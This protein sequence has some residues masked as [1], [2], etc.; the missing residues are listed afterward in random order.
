MTEQLPYDLNRID[1][2][3]L[4]DDFESM[5]V[6]L[7]RFQGFM[8]SNALG[9][10]VPTPKA[11]SENAPQQVSA[12]IHQILDEGE[13]ALRLY[14]LNDTLLERR[15]KNFSRFNRVTY[16]T[17]MSGLPLKHVGVT[18]ISDVRVGPRRTLSLL[19]LETY[20]NPPPEGEFVIS[21]ADVAHYMQTGQ[22]E[23]NLA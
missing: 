23:V 9:R 2:A 22:L 6:R 10:Y 8:G 13:Q 5:E 20:G 15:E 21:T 7:S 3:T 14:A 17:W 19:H 11:W 16:A 12:D 1:Q 18:D 4:R